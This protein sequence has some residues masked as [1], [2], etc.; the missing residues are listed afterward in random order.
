MYRI[1]FHGRGGQG[2]KTAANILGDAFFLAGYEVQDAPR[3]GAER[4]GAP[5]VAYV[6]ASRRQIVE[7][8]AIA[9]PDLVVVA[10]PGLLDIPAAGVRVGA[11]PATTLFVN[12]AEPVNV[13]RERL[14]CPGAVLAWPAGFGLFAGA[15]AAS[16]SAA[17]AGAAARLLG[18]FDRDALE[19]AIVA[20][21]GAR[22]PSLVDAAR[23]LGLA[24]YDALGDCHGCVPEGAE[25]AALPAGDPQWVDLAADEVGVAAPDIYA[26][27]NS[28]GMNTG[29]WRRHRPVIDYE[30][31]NR[32][33]WICSTLCP[34][35][36]IRV[37]ADRTP[38]IDYDH[39]KGCMVCVMA[40]PPH[41]IR[42][43]SEAE[44]A[45][46]QP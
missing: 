43:V 33:S 25:Q 35:S 3:Y 38:R 5:M 9:A 6:R 22:D 44:A 46:A 1:R 20:Q 36:A 37:D 4:R 13:L 7:R 31:C 2:M 28:G 10:D 16:I 21:S 11:S 26:P 29:S 32:C 14:A 24:A 42:Q 18:A 8:G 34:D 15:P 17:C 40:C 45:G 30:H 27:A 23:S 41:A 12:T 39:C 19:R